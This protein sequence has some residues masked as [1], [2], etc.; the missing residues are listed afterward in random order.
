MLSLVLSVLISGHGQSSELKRTV[1]DIDISGYSGTVNVTSLL[2]EKGE[3]VTVSDL[4]RLSAAITGAYHALGYT[5]CYV[6]EI[7]MGKDGVLHIV[8]WEGVIASVVK[9]NFSE[10]DSGVFDEVVTMPGSMYNE[11]D[12]RSSV[13]LFKTRTSV[14]AVKTDIV[15]ISDGRIELHV[16]LKRHRQFSSIFL[17]REPV[18]HESAGAEYILFYNSLQVSAAAESSLARDWNRKNNLSGK[19]RRGE[20]SGFAMEAAYGEID[21]TEAENGREFRYCGIRLQY[22][23]YLF[24]DFLRGILKTGGD[25]IESD[26]NLCHDGITILSEAEFKVLKEPERLDYSEAWGLT[27]RFRLGYHIQ[28]HEA[29]YETDIR[30]HKNAAVI[31]NV[32]AAEM[33]LALT[34]LNNNYSADAG[35]VYDHLF[36]AGD[37]LRRF[38]SR[39]IC[40][41]YSRF[42]APVAGLSLGPVFYSAGFME[43]GKDFCVSLG[44]GFRLTLDYGGISGRAEYA[45][46]NGSGNSF[47]RDGFMSFSVNVRI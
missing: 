13:T 41:I 28:G 22:D 47:F 4:K 8:L 42:S 34:A 38:D 21:E 39:G 20:K 19:I 7:R 9:E 35:Y 43:T 15:R 26:D 29:F 33:S 36:P 46:S 17:D 16:S 5:A 31:D 37:G 40:S 6:K 14:Q 10:K 12:Y 2:P 25:R 44:G 1:R 24:D 27:A 3:S 30:A 11:F 32:M 23:F 45:S 18:F